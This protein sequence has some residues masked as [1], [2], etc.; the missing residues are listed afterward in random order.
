MKMWPRFYRNR[1]NPDFMERTRHLGEAESIP[2]VTGSL[3]S[4]GTINTDAPVCT[5]RYT[6]Y[7]W[8]AHGIIYLMKMYVFFL[9]I[10]SAWA[11]GIMR[12]MTATQASMMKLPKSMKPSMRWAIIHVTTTISPSLHIYIFIFAEMASIIRSIR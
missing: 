1:S 6:I 2:T 9:I 5:Q 7:T 10:F 11:N 8:H 12:A 3:E 4:I